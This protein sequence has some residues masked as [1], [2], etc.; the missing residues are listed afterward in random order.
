MAYSRL[1]HFQ[2]SLRHLDTNMSLRE[3]VKIINRKKVFTRRN[4]FSSHICFLC[5][6]KLST[7][8]LCILTGCLHSFHKKCIKKHK[9]CVDEPIKCPTCVVDIKQKIDNMA[10]FVGVSKYKVIEVSPFDSLFDVMTQVFT[11]STNLKRK[12]TVWFMGNSE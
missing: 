7:F 12:S 9:K 8:D 1:F 11:F 4:S 2:G 10:M 5:D 6:K 3:T